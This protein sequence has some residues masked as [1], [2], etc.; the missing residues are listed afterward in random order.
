MITIGK[1]KTNTDG[2]SEI[3][4]NDEILNADNFTALE[5]LLDISKDIDAAYHW[6]KKNHKSTFADYIKQKPVDA[7]WTMQKKKLRLNKKI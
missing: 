6:L 5:C 7:N 3:V 1:I 2:V 4:F